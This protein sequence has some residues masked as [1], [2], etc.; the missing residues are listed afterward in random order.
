MP[1]SES[2]DADPLILDTNKSNRV[3]S[4]LLSKPIRNPLTYVT[5]QQTSFYANANEP[6]S[7]RNILC[8]GGKVCFGCW[9]PSSRSKGP[10]NQ[11]ASVR[12]HELGFRCAFRINFPYSADSVVNASTFH[13]EASGDRN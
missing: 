6:P 11:T 5:I 12:Q 8:Q 3:C 4:S 10:Y 2:S 13:F 1:L 7:S 9:E